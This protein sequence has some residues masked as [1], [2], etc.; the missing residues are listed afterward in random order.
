MSDRRVRHSPWMTEIVKGDPIQV[1]GRELVPV[2]RVTSRMR[3]RALVGSDGVS[4]GGW[5]FVHMRP[6]EI[7]DYRSGGS[8]HH[9]RIRSDAWRSVLWL[10][11]FFFGVPLAAVLLIILSGRSDDKGS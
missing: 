8:E 9:L 1:G 11:L 2:V 5:G 4:G 10:A 3:R 7:L 6:V